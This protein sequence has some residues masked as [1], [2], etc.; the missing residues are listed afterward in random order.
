[1]EKK[2]VSVGYCVMGYVGTAVVRAFG[3]DSLCYGLTILALCW[4]FTF[5]RFVKDFPKNY[6]HDTNVRHVKKSFN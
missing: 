3:R 6:L 1:M 2:A 4:Y 5:G